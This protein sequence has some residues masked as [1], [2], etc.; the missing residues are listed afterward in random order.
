M[1]SQTPLYSTEELSL[2]LSHFYYCTAALSESAINTTLKSDYTPGNAGKSSG[3]MRP[4]E[5]PPAAAQRPPDMTPE[6]PGPP[7]TEGKSSALNDCLS[8]AACAIHMQLSHLLN[9][10]VW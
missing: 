1:L 4:P 5:A 10:P 2:T 6:D 8:L 3:V 7:D 9:Q